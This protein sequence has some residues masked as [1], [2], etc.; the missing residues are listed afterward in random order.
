MEKEIT[1]LDKAK[2]NYK[3]AKILLNNAHDDCMLCL[4]GFHLQQAVEIAIGYQ[5]KINEAFD[6]PF[7]ER[8]LDQI[9]RIARERN[10]DIYM[11]DYIYEHSEMFAAWKD[12]AS[13]TGYSIERRKI[14]KAMP[15]VERYLEGC[16]QYIMELQKKGYSKGKR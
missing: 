13:A 7:W 3:V 11:T 6:I 16:E 4:V 1:L 9:I 12:K 2:A 15:E 10:I 5:L 8:D 14:E